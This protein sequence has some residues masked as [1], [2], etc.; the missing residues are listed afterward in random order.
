MIFLR[1]PLSTLMVSCLLLLALPG[2]LAHA[3]EPTAPDGGAGRARP[4]YAVEVD[5]AYERATH[6]S[7]RITS[8]LDDARRTRDARR[9]RCLDVTLSEVNSQVR[10]LGER[11]ERLDAALTHGDESVARHEAMLAGYVARHVGEVERR[12][13]E[14]SGLVDLREGTRV[15]VEV[16]RVPSAGE[17]VDGTALPL[18]LPPPF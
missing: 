13:V 14:C 17:P 11:A 4:A 18:T 2:G 9:A 6:V 7:R 3:N 15:T 5:A 1:R 12:A 16:E 8:M 10:M